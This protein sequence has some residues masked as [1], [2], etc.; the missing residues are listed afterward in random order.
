MIKACDETGKGLFNLIL[1]D[2]RF[3]PMNAYEPLSLAVSLRRDI[4]QRAVRIFR[5]WGYR[6]IEVPLLD[7]IE[8]DGIWGKDTRRQTFQVVDRDGNLLALRADV[9]PAVTKLYARQLRASTKVLRACY[10][11]R[12]VQSAHA[13]GRRQS[14]SYQIGVE[15]IGLKG[16]VAEVEVVLVCFEVLSAIGVEQCQLN[17]GSI[18][19]FNRL[20]DMTG[21]PA[22]KRLAIRSAMMDRDP[23][24]VR[25]ILH[26][27]GTRSNITGALEAVASLQTGDEQ[28]ARIK[29]LLPHD[30][31]LGESFDHL[32]DMVKLLSELGFS[33]RVNVDLGDLQ[34]PT[35]YTG[36]LFKVV[37]ESIG[38]ELGGG[39][40]YD[41]LCGNYGQ[42]AP[43]VGFALRLDALLE[44]LQPDAAEQ[45]SVPA[46]AA[47]RVDPARP[48]QGLRAVLERR[49]RDET[50]LVIQGSTG[51]PEMEGP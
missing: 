50:A 38:R 49:S 43:A 42:E 45:L 15:L 51:A 11:N 47:V 32:E 44:I 26:R 10:A 2:P 5:G 29:A 30:R 6:D 18:A 8:D 37:S 14:E 17:L 39:G 1:D 31:Q 40:R 4:I 33:E 28:I 16:L 7:D 36:V 35:Y 46:G 24:E 20:L 3:C 19:V 23:Y 41:S 34:G 25:Q 22:V 9:T 21:L 48:L 13:F 12:V 27:C